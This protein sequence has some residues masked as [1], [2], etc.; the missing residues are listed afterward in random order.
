[1]TTHHEMRKQVEQPVR[2]TE[3]RV[4]ERVEQRRE[5]MTDLEKRRERFDRQA[6]QWMD[7]EILPRLSVLAQTFP[8]S[9]PPLVWEGG[10]RVT[11]RFSRNDRYPVDTCIDVAIE[12]DSGFESAWLTFEA[13]IIPILMEYEREGRLEVDLR[14]AASL[15]VARFVEERIVRFVS[16]YLRVR[17]PDSFYQRDLQVTDPVCGMAFRRAVAAASVVHEG[18]TYFFCVPRCRDLFEADPERYMRDARQAG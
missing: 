5:K 4:Q 13:C 14:E 16:D 6:R 15:S 1:M 8:N 17:D 10:S 7:E 11:L 18:R 12:H 3:A 9:V 2:S